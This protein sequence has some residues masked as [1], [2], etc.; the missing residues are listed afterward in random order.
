M[1]CVPGVPGVPGA[2]GAED[3]PQAA[4]GAQYPRLWYDQRPVPS[5]AGHGSRTATV[6]VAPCARTNSALPRGFRTML[7]TTL[8]VSGKNQ[9]PFGAVA[10]LGERLNGIQEVR[11]SILL[12]ST[13]ISQGLSARV[14]PAPFCG[15]ATAKRPRR[16]A[17]SS[18]LPPPAP[19]PASATSEPPGNRMASGPC[20]TLL[21]PPM[22]ARATFDT[23]HTRICHTDVEQT[24]FR[25]SNEMA[26]TFH[27][28]HD[29]A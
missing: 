7:L 26:F 10:Q 6:H 18:P 15:L 16:A 20:L 28:F 14:T 1:P 19:S 22:Y 23:L 25:R 11:S 17:R 8:G 27:C 12:S 13:R 2:P 4:H 29:K 21:Y 24:S 5:M 9:L 3:P